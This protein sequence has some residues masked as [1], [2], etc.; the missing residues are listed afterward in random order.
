SGE[1]LNALVN[2]LGRLGQVDESLP[3]RVVQYVVD[4]SDEEVLLTL[5]GAKDAGDALALFHTLNPGNWVQLKSAL[6]ERASLLRP[7]DE[8]AAAVWVRLA[9]VFEAACRGAR[10]AVQAL[11]GWPTWLTIFLGEIMAACDIDTRRG[12]KRSRWSLE[13]FEAI[14]T[15]AGF[16]PD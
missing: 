15:C 1:H 3:V 8:V 10:V 16:P 4:G 5:G 7:G 6:E 12:A 11:P 2:Y 14:L 13:E 9:H